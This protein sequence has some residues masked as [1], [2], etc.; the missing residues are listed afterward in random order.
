MKKT[1]IT[2]IGLMLGPLCVIAQI[3]PA[4]AGRMPGNLWMVDSSIGTDAGLGYKLPSLRYGISLERPITSRIELQVSTTYSPDH[5]FITN[6][7]NSFLASAQ[8]LFWI[9]H[10][11]AAVG[12]M[13][14]SR[15]WTSQFNK[16]A[17]FPLVGIAI[18]DRWMGELPGRM[19]ITYEF[20]TGCVWATAGN[21]CLLQSNRLQGV[22]FDQE[23][24]VWP[25][26]RVAL[27][28]GFYN[29]CDQGNPF[30]PNVP[31]SCHYTV[32]SALQ[33]RFEFA[34]LGSAP[35]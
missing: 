10:R 28:Y 6:D 26:L 20:P 15:L 32:T 24:R 16:S 11:V 19:Y 22:N 29:F 13:H 30:A 2:L 31:R 33:F 7:G 8:S 4:P 12:G 34:N 1:L 35:Y 9:N 23:F 5:K 14:F 21:P 18:R 17:F 27:L 25:H 3:P